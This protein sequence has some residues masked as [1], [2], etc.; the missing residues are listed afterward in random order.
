MNS[1][2]F[3]CHSQEKANK[4]DL[5]GF[6]FEFTNPASNRVKTKGSRIDV[7]ESLNAKAIQ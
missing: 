3:A 2:Y 6:G 4:E 7:S 5:K 1:R